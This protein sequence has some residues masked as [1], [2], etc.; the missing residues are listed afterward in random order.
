MVQNAIGEIEKHRKAEL[1]EFFWT[2]GIPVEVQTAIV[3]FTGSLVLRRQRVCCVCKRSVDFH[4]EKPEA[5]KLILQMKQK[6]KQTSSGKKTKNVRRKLRNTIEQLNRAIYCH[7]HTKGT[8]K[9]NLGCTQVGEHVFDDEF[10]C[11]EAPNDDES[12]QTVRP[13]LIINDR[14]EITIFFRTHVHGSGSD[15]WN[16]EINCD[17]YTSGSLWKVTRVGEY[18]QGSEFGVQ[19]GWIVRKV[20]GKEVCSKTHHVARRLLNHGK[21]HS[22]TFWSPPGLSKY[23]HVYWDGRNQKWRARI[24]VGRKRYSGGSYVNERECALAVNRLCR[25]FGLPPSNPELEGLSLDGKKKSLPAPRAVVSS[26]N[27]SK[28]DGTAQKRQ[29]IAKRNAASGKSKKRR[30][31]AKMNAASRKSTLESF[32][33]QEHRHSRYSGVSWCK[34]MSKWKVKRLIKGKQQ[35]GGY[36][37]HEVKAAKVSDALARRFSPNQCKINF[38]TEQEIVALSPTA[39]EKFLLYSRSA[40][41]KMSER[42]FKRYLNYVGLGFYG[43]TREEKVEMILTLVKKKVPRE[44]DEL[45]AYLSGMNLPTTG[46]PKE[47]R[48]RLID[49]LKALIKK[50]AV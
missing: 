6:L 7:A 1:M 41:E 49:A 25:H 20:N 21:A 17:N 16:F 13:Q 12:S 31:I 11:Q 28:T 40:L 15:E 33:S 32:T 4:V 46:T 29:K 5:R 45:R 47:L 24:Y 10:M 48:K 2:G 37:Q 43:M 38:P 18:G 44:A 26:R 3:E 27:G 50:T 8:I 22:I 42:R 35:F 39:S 19:E 9:G 23:R 14:N 30:K 36:F 34:N